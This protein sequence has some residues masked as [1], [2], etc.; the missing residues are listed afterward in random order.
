MIISREV[1]KRTV[2]AVAN[3]MRAPAYAKSV[4]AVDDVPERSAVVYFAAIPEEI[5]QLEQWQYPLQTLG[6]RHPVVVLVT[7]PDIGRLVEE[8]TP[9][10]V[11]FAPRGA[12]LEQLVHE[13]R[14]AV[15]LYVNHREPNFRMLRYEQVS[16]VYLGHGE[17]DKGASA[18]HQN[19]AYDYCPVA[20]E[21]GQERLAEA[22][23]LFDVAVRAPIIGRPQLDS[24]DRVAAMA[25]PA[26]VSETS[27][28]TVLYAP[29]W[30]GGL[31][32]MAFGTVVS[33][34]RAIVESLL[35]DP[36]VR[37]IYRPHPLTGSLDPAHAAADH[38]LRARISS[39]GEP[40]IVDTG[41]YGWALDAADAAIVD[42]SSVAYDWLSTGK[43]MVITAPADERARPT[44]SELLDVAPRLT[45]KSAGQA[46]AIVRGLARG[47]DPRWTQLVRRHFGDTSPGAS[48]ASFLRALDTAIRLRTS[49]G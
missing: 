40:H 35:A 28:R 32:S 22:L 19:M 14:P 10:P 1:V 20:G 34:G 3:R 47:P 44:S 6:E 27:R 11:L 37:L 4:L 13:R 21:A 38:D 16:H 17:S 9:F 5:Y 42:I 8:H 43:P 46:D 30:E 39:A 24:P 7:R 15:I 41:S 26:N 33:H 29:T 12:Q 18:S 2:Q 36:D 31:P 48:T 45:A 49:H 23:P 25:R